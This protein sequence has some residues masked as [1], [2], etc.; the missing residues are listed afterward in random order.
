MHIPIELMSYNGFWSIK[1]SF[2]TNAIIAHTFPGITTFW[3]I[4]ATKDTVLIITCPSTLTPAN[5]PL[6]GHAITIG[7]PAVYTRSRSISETCNSGSSPSPATGA[8]LSGR[9]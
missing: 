7:V 9:I 5:A 3:T 6:I 2:E 1:I 4:G 8:A